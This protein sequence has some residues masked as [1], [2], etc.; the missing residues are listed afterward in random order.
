MKETLHT[1]AISWL[2]TSPIPVIAVGNVSSG[3]DQRWPM[4]VVRFKGPHTFYRVAG[5][6]ETKGKMADPYGCWWLDETSLHTI[7]AKIERLDM[8]EG[9]MPADVLS[10]AKSLPLHYRALT[11]VCEDWN[12][13]REQ[14][15]LT[16]PHGQELTG[17]CGRIASQP[18]RSSL[19]RSSPKT[20]WLPG[21][22]EQVFFKR[23]IRREERNI[24]PL[25]VHWVQLW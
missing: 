8:F 10:R 21:E 19:S 12:D 23:A 14:V 9:W 24:N 6:D 4:S 11:A 13:L 16:L 15:V 2:R 20:P 7:F 22:L 25:W 5:W 1:D 3:F 17:L 18:L